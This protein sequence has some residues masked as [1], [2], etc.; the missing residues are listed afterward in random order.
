MDNVMS[1]RFSGLSAVSLA[2]LNASNQDKGDGV[3]RKGTLSRL[4][5]AVSLGS[6][7]GSG[8]KKS[9]K[10]GKVWFLVDLIFDHPNVEELGNILNLSNPK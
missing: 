8:E 7:S 5:K 1:I 9:K 2:D 6:L 4:K 10:V 3:S